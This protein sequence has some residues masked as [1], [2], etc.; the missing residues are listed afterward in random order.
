MNLRDLWENN[1]RANI[2]I[3]RVSEEKKKDRGTK[4]YLK[5]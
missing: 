5:K 1:E 4:K 2:H 3:I